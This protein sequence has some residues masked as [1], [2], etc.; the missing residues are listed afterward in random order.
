LVET[1]WLSSLMTG[2]FRR[3]GPSCRYRRGLLPLL[4]EDEGGDPDDE[5][6]ALPALHRAAQSIRTGRGGHLGIEISMLEK[7]YYAGITPAAMTREM[8]RTMT[9][10]S[11]HL[12]LRMSRAAVSRKP[13]RRAQVSPSG[14]PIAGAHH[15]GVERK[16]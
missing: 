12:T 16:I 14:C 10:S 13:A 5:D 8:H 2:N 7:M 3:T 11:C 1:F 4:E 9:G 6:Q 15:A